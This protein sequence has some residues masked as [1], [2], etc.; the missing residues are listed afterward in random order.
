VCKHES[1]VSHAA[2]GAFFSGAREKLEAQQER[3]AKLSKTLAEHVKGKA[4]AEEEIKHLRQKLL[5]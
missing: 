2:L 1:H 3:H 4:M 5:V